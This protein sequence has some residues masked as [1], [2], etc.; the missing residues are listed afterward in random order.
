MP[1]VWE[2]TITIC[3]YAYM[4]L[5]LYY[6][7][8]PICLYAYM[9]ICLYAYMPICLYAYM[10][11]CLYV[12]TIT[13]CLYAYVSIPFLGEQGNWGTQELGNREQGTGEYLCTACGP[14]GQY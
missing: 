3:L 4:S 9:S 7:Y 14:V 12:Y 6:Y 13:I 1:D 10:S 5:C 11:I 2:I 8:M